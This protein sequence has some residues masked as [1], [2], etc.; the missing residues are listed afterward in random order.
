MAIDVYPSS[1]KNQYPSPYEIPYPPPYPV[2]GQDP[3]EPQPQ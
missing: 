1:Y 2:A 3:Q